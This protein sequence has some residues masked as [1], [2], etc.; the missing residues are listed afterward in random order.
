MSGGIA[1]VLDGRGDF[2]RGCDRE[3]VE[4]FTLDDP[5]EVD[6]VRLG[7][8]V[9]NLLH[10]AAKYTPDGGHIELGA[11]REGGEIVLRG[12]QVFDGYR[13]ETDTDEKMQKRVEHDLY[14]IENWSVLFDLYILL[15]TPLALMTKNENAVVSVP[16]A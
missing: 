6:E 7:Q 4:L 2:P 9:Q 13:G 16:R 3:M 8:I 15:K 14:Y 11:S 10:N 12:P 1:Y 5:A